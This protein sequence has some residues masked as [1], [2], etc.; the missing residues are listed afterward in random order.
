MREIASRGSGR[1]R[2]IITVMPYV[3][4]TTQTHEIPEC[5][6]LYDGRDTEVKIL[7]LSSVEYTQVH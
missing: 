2:K 3:V 4:P 6:L 5:I 1:Q 7:A